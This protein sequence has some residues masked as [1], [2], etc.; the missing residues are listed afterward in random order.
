MYGEIC[1]SAGTI[2]DGRSGGPTQIQVAAHEVGMEMS[3]EDIL[4]RRIALIGQFEIDIDVPQWINDG[5]FTLAFDII[6]GFAKTACVELLD[7]HK[8][9]PP[10]KIPRLCSSN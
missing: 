2:H 7:K 6:R 10:S 5:C 8:R 4:D 3:F 9:Y 1:Y